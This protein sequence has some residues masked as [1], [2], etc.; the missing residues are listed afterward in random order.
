M[1][2]IDKL[3]LTLSDIE[4]ALKDKIIEGLEQDLE[5]MTGMDDHDPFMSDTTIGREG[6]MQHDPALAGGGKGDVDPDVA[7]PDDD[8]YMAAL[9]PRGSGMMSS[10][11]ME[12][13]ADA[14]SSMDSD[15]MGDYQ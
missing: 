13:Y 3:N 4:S 2:Q 7:R 8:N 10:A 6:R 5:E 11:E 1:S 14:M 9:G 15:D 12:A